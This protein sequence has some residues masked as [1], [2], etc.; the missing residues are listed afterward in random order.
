MTIL[1]GWKA[2]LAWVIIFVAVISAWEMSKAVFRFG[3][4]LGILL[5][6]YHDRKA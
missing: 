5:S 2:T 4:G 6:Q 3:V 1:T